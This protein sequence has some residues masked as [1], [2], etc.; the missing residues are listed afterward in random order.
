MRWYNEPKTQRTNRGNAAKTEKLTNTAEN[1]SPKN[2]VRIYSFDSLRAVLQVASV[3]SG[4][5][6]GNNSLYKNPKQNTYILF[7]ECRCEKEQELA[8]LFHVLSEY[9]KRING[10]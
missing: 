5:Y 9:G 6:H 7:L 4:K 8:G 10:E 2:S 3:V 1:T